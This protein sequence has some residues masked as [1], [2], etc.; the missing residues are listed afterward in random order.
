MIVEEVFENW[1][2]PPS[3]RRPQGHVKTGVTKKGNKKR[4]LRGRTMSLL[5]DEEGADEE[6]DEDGCPL[7]GSRPPALVIHVTYQHVTSTRT[8]STIASPGQ[9]R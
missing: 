5:E 3:Q 6:V 2:T 7:I 9:V 4:G 8:I 1:N